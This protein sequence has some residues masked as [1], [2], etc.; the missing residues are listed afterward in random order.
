MLY[1]VGL[2]L[3]R[4]QLVRKNYNTIKIVTYYY[5]HYLLLIPLKTFKIILSK[6]IFYA[7]YAGPP[8]GYF[9]PSRI[10]R[11]PRSSGSGPHHVMSKKKK[12]I[13]HWKS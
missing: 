12:I 10:A 1:K 9:V 5:Y 13:M 11:D 8:A 2:D 3:I 6:T 4:M 7:F